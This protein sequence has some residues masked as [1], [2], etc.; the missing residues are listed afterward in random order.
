LTVDGLRVAYGKIV[1]VPDLSFKV[2]P[3]RVLAVLG[4]NGAGKTT[5]ANALSGLIPAVA[6]AILLD[7]EDVKGFPPDR[8]VRAGLG[9]LPDQ[10]AI[11]PSLTVVENLRMAFTHEPSRARMREK[12]A[13]A[14]RRF[15]ALERRLGIIAGR[16]SGGEQQ[17]LAA[18]RYLVDPPRVLILDEPSHGLAP[19]IVSDLFNALGRLRGL[20]TI[21]VIEQFVTRAVE[22][23]DDVIVLS[24][25]E[26]AH[27]GS[28]RN[29]TNE[30]ATELYRLQ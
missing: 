3:G 14:C 10:R 7:G 6:S 29:F 17:M 25:G 15:P 20:T 8:R 21:V 16:L 4:P 13:E 9:H 23:A 18:V 22:L 12:I 19:V 1:A 11:F 24:H 30:M 27:E 2:E 5:T 26:I 28:A